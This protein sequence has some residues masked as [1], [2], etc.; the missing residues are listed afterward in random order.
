MKEEKINKLREERLELITSMNI[1]RAENNGEKA[2][3][4][5]KKHSRLK[6]VSS[7]L[8]RLTNNPIYL[9]K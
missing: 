3:E 2:A 4:Y 1:T 9:I 7:D 6:E 5:K 8:Y